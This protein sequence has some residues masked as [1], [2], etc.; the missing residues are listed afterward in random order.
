ME[1]KKMDNNLTLVREFLSDCEVKLGSRMQEIELIGEI[2]L[3]DETWE[4]IKECL[5]LFFSSY[6]YSYAINY[7]IQNYP[8]VLA[9]FMVY[10]GI[11]YYDEGRYWPNLKA[12]LNIESSNYYRDLTNFFETFLRDHDMPSFEEIGGRKYLNAILT[13]G[14]IPN[15]CLKDFFVFFNRYIEREIVREVW[16]SGKDRDSEISNLITE[17]RD[18]GKE[19]FYGIDKPVYRF[20]L[21]GNKVSLD[22]LDRFIETAQSFN[23]KDDIEIIADETGLPERIIKA[24]QE[25]IREGGSISSSLES[26]LTYFKIPKFYINPD[27]GKGLMIYLP[28]CSGNYYYCIDETIKINIQIDKD[29]WRYIPPKEKYHIEIKERG[30][31]KRKE[32]FLTG[33]SKEN[34]CMFFEEA[35]YHDGSYNLVSIKPPSTFNCSDIWI[36]HHKNMKI[37]QV[38]RTEG[39]E[40]YNE[41]NDY[42]IYK[43]NLTE[44]KKIVINDKIYPVTYKD[45]PSIEFRG[46]DLLVNSEENQ[47]IPLYGDKLPDLL[48]PFEKFTERWKIKIIKI[49]SSLKQ[50]KTFPLID[51]DREDYKDNRGYWLLLP[52]E[53]P[54]L[55]NFLSDGEY[56]IKLMTY[57]GGD[58]SLSLRRLRRLKIKKEDWIYPRE[59][60]YPPVNIFFTCLKHWKLNFEDNQVKGVVCG[61]SDSTRYYK[62]ECPD[63]LKDIRGHIQYNKD[64]IMPFHICI[65]LLEWAW[66]GLEEKIKP[67]DWSGRKESIPKISFTASKS[68]RLLLRTWSKNIAKRDFKLF[69]KNKGETIQ[70]LQE[71][72]IQ[73]EKTLGRL[74]FALSP[75]RDTIR[76]MST[77]ELNIVL[78][79]NKKIEIP[80][81]DITFNWKASIHNVTYE[82][83]KIH[84]RVKNYQKLPSELITKVVIGNLWTLEKPLLIEEVHLNE[85]ETKIAIPYE[86]N[87]YDLLKIQLVLEEKDSWHIPDY[88][89]VIWQDDGEHSYTG[90][91]LPDKIKLLDIESSYRNNEKTITTKGISSYVISYDEHKRIS[92]IK[93]ILAHNKFQMKM[94]SYQENANIDNILLISEEVN[95]DGLKIH[96]EYKDGKLFKEL[97]FRR[98]F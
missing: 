69:I 60:I 47:G 24:Y 19:N 75:L 43:Y 57:L 59:G 39:N 42:V 38:N 65:P 56:E 85:G 55:V 62:V 90:L 31:N 79:I 21:H 23:K 83:K 20:I 76:D 73:H 97:Y 95:K 22:F 7:I 82:G 18:Y 94:I 32:W 33:V 27:E 74:L 89:N 35:Y 88:N 50:I 98:F 53:Q 14:G 45:H 26:S 11:K 34:L 6:D 81:M 86:V 17:W 46:G 16:R 78:E 61:K 48:I 80:V 96:R 8:N 5:N 29:R 54:G 1:V 84:F 9:V 87:H 51:L 64:N 91:I 70:E 37:E 2:S 10:L 77:Q 25:W 93:R 28:E 41:W 12:T 68:P 67:L 15:H 3:R 4:K 71:T 13:H 92:S 58:Q 52:L 30:G 36:L 63:Y 44:C 72:Y 40:L 49:E 66:L